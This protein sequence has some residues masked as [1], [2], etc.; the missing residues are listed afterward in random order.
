MSLW[1]CWNKRQLFC[2]EQKPGPGVRRLMV[3]LAASIC[4]PKSNIMQSICKEIVNDNHRTFCSRSC[5]LQIDTFHTGVF[6]FKVTLHVLNS[7]MELSNFN[8]IIFVR[9]RTVTVKMIKGWVVFILNL[10]MI[11]K[12]RDARNSQQCTMHLKQNN[13]FCDL[14]IRFWMIYGSHTLIL[15]CMLS[16]LFEGPNIQF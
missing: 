8:L 12:S 5:T 14:I 1:A 2:F 3:R 16:F 4:G 13:S 11:Y 9:V 15:D 6:F 7:F 10:M